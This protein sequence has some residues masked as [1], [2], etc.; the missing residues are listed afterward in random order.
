MPPIMHTAGASTN[1]N[2]IITPK[3]NYNKTKKNKL[4]K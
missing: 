1:S 3:N 4:E 2:L